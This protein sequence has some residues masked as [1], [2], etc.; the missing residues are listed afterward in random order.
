RRGL[1]DAVQLGVHLNRLFDLREGGKLGHV[2]GGVHRLRRVLVPHL[3]DQEFQ[4]GLVIHRGLG[5]RRRLAGGGRNG[6]GHV[7]VHQLA[8]IAIL[9]SVSSPSSRSASSAILSSG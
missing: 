1:Q 7:D 4:E 8:P 3:G 2:L 5:F 9:R 6:G